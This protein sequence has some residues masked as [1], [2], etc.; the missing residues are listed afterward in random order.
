MTRSYTYSYQVRINRET[1][2][3]LS[4]IS[5]ALGFINETPG[6]RHGDPSPASLLDKMAERYR[7]DPDRVLAALVQA[8]IVAGETA[9]T[10]EHFG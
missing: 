10:Q 9:V 2:P 4:D 1:R 5:E 7:E 3:I 8:G 6:A